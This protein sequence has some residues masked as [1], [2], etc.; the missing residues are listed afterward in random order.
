MDIFSD[1]RLISENKNVVIF[2][3]ARSGGPWP[4]NSFISKVLRSEIPKVIRAVFQ[5]SRIRAF[6][7]I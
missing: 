5:M 3:G 6:L 4:Y 1:I 7:N 2:H